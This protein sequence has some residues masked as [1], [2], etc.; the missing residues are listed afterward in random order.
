[1][2]DAAGRCKDCRR[3]AAAGRRRC[4]RCA[5]AHS[6]REAAR[7]E[8]RRRSASCIVCGLPAVVDLDGKPLSHCDKHRVYYA[9]RR[10]GVAAPKVGDETA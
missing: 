1:M 5:K 9:Q 3:P 2:S 10:A 6:K 7:R 8:A 4:K